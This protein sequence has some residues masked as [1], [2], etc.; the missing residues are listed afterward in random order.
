MGSFDEQKAVAVV[1]FFLERSSSGKLNDLKLM[2]LLYTAERESLR[3]QTT[4]ITQSHFF[5]MQNGP[6]LSEVYDLYKNGGEI[7]DKHVKFVP[8][9]RGVCP[10]NHLELLVPFDSAS[11]LS[12]AELKILEA[13][14]EKY[15]HKSKWN[16]VDITHTFPE[17]DPD[18]ATHKTA[19]PITLVEIF[20]KGFH[21]PV[22][23][24]RSKAE[25]IE[26]YSDLLA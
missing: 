3:T 10:E 25:D 9:R 15:G 8:Y 26:Y 16:L 22:D 4:C 7:W 17:W 6:V 13:V 5:S 20:Q 2:K 24:A 14:W 11:V 21:E 23:I 19:F 12:V 1:S 18:A